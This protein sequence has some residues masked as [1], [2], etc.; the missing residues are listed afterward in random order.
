MA[1]RRADQIVEI[2]AEKACSLVSRFKSQGWVSCQ[3]LAPKPFLK[4]LR[5][6]N[7]NDESAEKR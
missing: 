4:S 6:E 1:Y 2:I 5:D 7:I 3:S